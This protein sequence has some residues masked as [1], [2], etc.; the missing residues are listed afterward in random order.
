MCYC[1]KYVANTV[2]DQPRRSSFVFVVWL[3]EKNYVTFSLIHVN[4]TNTS[5]NVYINRTNCLL[6]FNEFLD[7]NVEYFSAL[8]FISECCY[9]SRN[10]SYRSYMKMLQMQI[11]KILFIDHCNLATRKKLY[12]SF[13]FV[14]FYK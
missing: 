14:V 3:V 10:V 9:I 12:C 8:L 11:V 7:T 4:S 6:V 2:L 13:W 1:Y 5:L